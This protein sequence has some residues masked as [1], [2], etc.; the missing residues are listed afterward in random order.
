[1]KERFFHIEFFK[2][3][4]G[5]YIALE[6]NNR[7]AGGITIDLYNYAYN[8]DLCELYAKVVV[9]EEVPKYETDNYTATVSR[10]NKYNYKYSEDDVNI[11]YHEKIRMVE[12]VPTVFA[13]AM[14][15]VIFIVT[16]GS[17]EEL[18]EIIDFIQEKID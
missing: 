18:I 8:W 13:E 5:E 15:D 14:G 6:Y 10:R 17:K 12:Y 2:L 11:E 9:G 1:M 3:P 16:V 7:I 4:D